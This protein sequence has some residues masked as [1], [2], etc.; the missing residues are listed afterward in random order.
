MTTPVSCFT[1]PYL[2]VGAGV[3]WSRILAKNLA[4]WLRP[5]LQELITEDELHPPLT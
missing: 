4:A 2:E 3:R 5:E 1:P